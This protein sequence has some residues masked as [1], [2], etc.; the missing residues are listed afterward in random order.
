METIIDNK[1]VNWNEI[2]DKEKMNIVLNILGYITSFNTGI[3]KK[4]NNGYFSAKDISDLINNLYNISI[5]EKSLFILHDYHLLQIWISP[6]RGNLFL[7]DLV[8]ENR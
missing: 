1:N 3:L 5:V 7:C 8:L 2:S 6:E 4:K